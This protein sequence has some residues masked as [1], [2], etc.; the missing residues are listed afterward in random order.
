MSRARRRYLAAGSAAT[1]L[2]ALGSVGAAGASPGPEAPAATGAATSSSFR[3]TPGLSLLDKGGNNTGAAEPSIR[4]DKTGNVYVTGPVGVPTGGCPFW[5]VHPDTLNAMNKPYEYLGKFDTEHA[6]AGGGD[7]DIA[8]GGKDNA[9]QNRFENLAVSSLNLAN[10]TTNQSDDGGTTFRTPAN[11]L[12]GGQIE[13]VDR[14]WQAADTSLGRNYLTV[15]DIATANIQVSV[16][17]D[18]G[19]QYISNEPAIQGQALIA[20]TDNNTFGNIVVNPK[21][22]KLYTVFVAPTP[23][24]NATSGTL[25]PQHVVYVAVGEPCFISCMDAQGKPTP[26]SWTDHV[27]YN[28]TRPG[29][30]LSHI[31][32]VIAIDAGGNVYTTWSD[33]DQVFFSHSNAAATTWSKPVGVDKVVNGQA[34]SHSNMFPWMVGG[35]A[36]VVDIV[37]YEGYLGSR[38][39]GDGPPDDSAGLNNNCKNQWKV[40]F[41]QTR[42]A[43]GAAPTFTRTDATGIIHKGS[44]CDN[45]L[46]CSTNGGDRTL[47]DFFQIDLDP[48]GAANIAFAAD[49]SS[50]GTAQVKYTRQCTGLSAKS[51]Q[52]IRY[53]CTALTPPPPP[54]VQSQC[55]GTN[56][57][58][59]PAGDATNPLGSP[60]STDQVDITNISFINGSAG[61]P[62]RLTTKMELKALSRVPINGT[63]DTYY[64]VVWAYGGRFYA[65]LAQEPTAAGVAEFYYGEFDPSNNQLKTATPTTGNFDQANNTISVNVPLSGVGNPTIPVADDANAA[66]NDPYGLTISGLGVAGSGLVFVRPDDRAPNTGGGPDWSVCP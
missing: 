47:L 53:R 45:G 34:A 41:A 14:E 32:P 18:G 56:L 40:E 55:D 49:V 5:R 66:V 63:T 22:H 2:L 61:T 12:G 42:N 16:S 57:V 8:T 51:D 27:V 64:Y 19:Y 7:C 20:A 58:S 3:F 23:L 17:I 29:K 35:K 1:L 38:C 36:G 60:G 48:L 54:T 13:I 24:E 21:T 43:T 6:S 31:F 10:L 65:S 37:Y 30:T 9:P 33:T 4:V 15:H 39:F 26:I 46:N 25:A 50:P 44:I 11:P 52:Q 62:P 59:D 28:D